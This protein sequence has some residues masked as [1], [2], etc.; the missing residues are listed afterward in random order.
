MYNK[1]GVVYKRI[2]ECRSGRLSFGAVRL[3][4]GYEG[5]HMRMYGGT[6]VGNVRTGNEDA[7]CINDTWC[8]VA[9]GMGGHKGGEVA[10]RTAIEAVTAYLATRAL[11]PETIAEA[12]VYANRR[13]HD[14]AMNDAALDNMGTTFCGV[15]DCGNTLC[16]ANVGDSRCYSVSPGE[17]KQITQD[18]SIVAE[19][20]RQGTLRPTDIATHPHKHVIT[21]AIGTA[22]YV[23]VDCMTLAPSSGDILV[24]CSDGLTD[25]LSDERICDVVR[26]TAPERVCDALIA[27]A[28][29]AGGVDNVTVIVILP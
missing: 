25:M 17:M 7:Y 29:D 11:T 18:H 20:V 26:N 23:D 28:L 10:S 5:Q 16:I 21:R 2:G 3:L 6:H 1:I 15:F 24:V 13:V 8:A 4:Y 19:L 14:M 12:V 27:A 9:D 22:G